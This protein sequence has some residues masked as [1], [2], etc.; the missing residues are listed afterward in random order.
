MD[1]Q[2]P[3]CNDTSEISCGAGSGPYAVIIIPVLLAVSTVVVAA[4]VVR[5]VCCKR[6]EEERTSV[7]TS[8]RDGKAGGVSAQQ[9]VLVSTVSGPLAAIEAPGPSQVPEDCV[10]EELEVLHTG[11]YGPV[12]KARLTRGGATSTVVVKA[13]R[14]SS[15]QPEVKE[16]VAWARFHA[17]VSQHENLVRMLFCRTQHQ[18]MCLVLEA[19]SPGNLLHFLWA[20]RNGD[21]GIW[22][23][24]QPFSERSVCSVA[25]QVAAGLEYLSSAH[26][27][28]HGDVA[29]RSVLIGSGLSVR[30]SGLGMAFQAWHTG[31]VA[32]RR[33]AEVPLKWQAPERGMGLPIT[34]HSD[35]WSFGVLLYE[36]IT[37]GAP[38][39]QGLEPQDVFTQIQNS[40]RMEKPE[41]CGTPLYDL[42]KH[43][44]MWNCKDRPAFSAIIKLL[45]SYVGL[46]ETKMLSSQESMDIF[47]YSRRAGVFP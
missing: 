6:P 32:K 41:G 13:L 7:S 25:E 44:W 35:V 42:M 26:G 5:S 28:F 18:P 2:T 20:L 23:Q 46:A 1:S 43:C 14:E 38:P 30:L 19:V 37:L 10:L 24:S 4:L 22:R 33:A 47:E 45:K 34:E 27:L 39:Y 11:R 40:Y 31:K 15:S 9:S 3:P 8:N 29:A 16:F 36:L 17:D 12:C 21:S